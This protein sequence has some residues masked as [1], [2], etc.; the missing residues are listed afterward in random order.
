MVGPTVNSIYP[1]CN[2]EQ[3]SGNILSKRRLRR[4]AWHVGTSCFCHCSCI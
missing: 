1:D 2:L 4:V 3:Q